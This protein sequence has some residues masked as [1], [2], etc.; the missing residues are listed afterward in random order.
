MTFNQIERALGLR[1]AAIADQTPIAW[2]NKDFTP[3]T[4]YFEFRHVPTSRVDET[5]GGGFAYQTG[6]ALITVVVARDGFSTEANDLA[7]AVADGF[8]KALRLDAGAGKVVISAPASLGTPF[9][10][11]VYFRLPVSVSYITEG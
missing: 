11:G 4:P 7:Q 2:P 10:D 8:P 9:V 3:A 1:L 5:T 6:I